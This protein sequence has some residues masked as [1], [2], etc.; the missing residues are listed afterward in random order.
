[1][2]N[3]TILKYLH[4]FNLWL[5][6]HSSFAETI[7]L[8]IVLKPVGISSNCNISKIPTIAPLLKCGK[9]ESDFK[10]RAKLSISID[11]VIH[12]G[13]I[14]WIM[15]LPEGII[16][17]YTT[18]YSSINFH[19]SDIFKI[20]RSLNKIEARGHDDISVRMTKCLMSHCL[21]YWH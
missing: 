8:Q 6:K 13:V 20:V 14:L 7:T 10:I 12:T 19:N 1:M 16:C 17:N 11:H 18:R 21:S 2:Y 9:L 3:L 15:K 4:M 5:H